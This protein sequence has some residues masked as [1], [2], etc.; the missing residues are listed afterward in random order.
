MSMATLNIKVSPRRMLSAREAAIY[1]G[2][3]PKHFAIDCSVSPVQMPRGSKMY[4][5]RD[6]DNWLD[7]LKNEFPNSDDEIVGRLGA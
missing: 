5:T 3:S 2:L 4:D 1:C 7:G 6:L